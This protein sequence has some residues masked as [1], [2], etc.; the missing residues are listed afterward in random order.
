VTGTSYSPDGRLL[1]TGSWDGT[2]RIYDLAQTGVST[3]LDIGQRV[4]MV[5]FSNDGTLLGVASGTMFQKGQLAVWNVADW[6]LRFSVD[7]DREVTALCFSDTAD[8]VATAVGRGRVYVWDATSGGLLTSLLDGPAD[9][10]P[11]LGFWPG[12]PR[13]LAGLA[14]TGFM[15]IWDTETGQL[16]G[17]LHARL[18]LTSSDFSND[19]TI[20]ALGDDRGTVGLVT[21][22]GVQ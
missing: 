20:L 14:L 19:G 12:Q 13:Y 15:F 8:R 4:A 9:T 17:Q 18:R 3:R 11:R 10:V 5:R 16:Q 22:P 2:V 7:M 6:S 1:A 21:I